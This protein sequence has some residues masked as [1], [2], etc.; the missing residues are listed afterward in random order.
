MFDP[1]KGREIYFCSDEMVLSVIEKVKRDDKSSKK[2]LN[3]CTILYS[4]FV[5]KYG[6]PATGV[7]HKTLFALTYVPRGIPNLL[8]C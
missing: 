5:S 6:G 3:N 7:S 1:Q 2:K 4:T 8:K